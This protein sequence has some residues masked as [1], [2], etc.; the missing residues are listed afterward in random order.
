M[1]TTYRRPQDTGQVWRTARL[2]LKTQR[3]KQRFTRFV[4]RVVVLVIVIVSL[5]LL[6]AFFTNQL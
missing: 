1:T 5:T 3:A 2:E 6:T 4:V